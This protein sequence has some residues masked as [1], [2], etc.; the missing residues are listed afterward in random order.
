MDFFYLP[1]SG[2]GKT[3]AFLQGCQSRGVGFDGSRGRFLSR[4]TGP[5]RRRSPRLPPTWHSGPAVKFPL[6]RCKKRGME[7]LPVSAGGE[8]HGCCCH[9]WRG[10]PCLLAG[11]LRK[12]LL[13]SS[14]RQDPGSCCEQPTPGL[15]GGCCADTPPGLPEAVLQR[16]HARTPDSCCR[17]PPA[18]TPGVLCRA[19]P[20]R[21]PGV[22]Q[23]SP[24]QA[25]GAAFCEHPRQGSRGL[26][27]NSSRQDSRELRAE[28]FTP[29]LPGAAAASIPSGL[30]PRCRLLEGPRVYTPQPHPQPFCR[31]HPQPDTPQPSLPGLK[32][33]QPCL[34]RV[35]PKSLNPSTRAEDRKGAPLSP[36]QGPPDASGPAHPRGPTHAQ[37]CPIMRVPPTLQ[38]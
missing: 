34:A 10:I 18:R 27:L 31:S 17:Q 3:C 22:L 33:P 38:S 8:S 14:P 29:G 16:A 24:R 15:P 12:G 19:G 21:T 37:L 28:H 25:Q 5:L 30:Q 9:A 35:G 6:P 11:G 7:H 4:G 26:L 2:G 36:T 1:F 13:Q 23:S 20:A 32:T